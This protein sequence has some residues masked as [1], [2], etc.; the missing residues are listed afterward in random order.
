[1]FDLTVRTT[2]PTTPG[3]EGGGASSSTPTAIARID[4]TVATGRPSISAAAA[5][6]E[7][8]ERGEE[9]RLEAREVEVERLIRGA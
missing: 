5:D 4:V 3:G 1:L 6:G 8:G 2:V 7:R 9:A